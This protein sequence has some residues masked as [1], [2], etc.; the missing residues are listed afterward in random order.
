MLNFFMAGPELVWWD[1]VALGPGGTSPHRLVI[2]HSAGAITEYFDD[3][4]RALIRQGELEEL[5]ATACT[6]ATQRVL[7]HDEPVVAHDR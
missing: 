5:L 1:L 4:T 7:R 2:H 3:A 6:D